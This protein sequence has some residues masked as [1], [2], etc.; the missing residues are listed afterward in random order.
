[1]NHSTTAWDGNQSRIKAYKVTF[2]REPNQSSEK[3]RCRN[4]YERH[5]NPTTI[6]LKDPS[7]AFVVPARN[8]EVAEDT[9]YTY[10]KLRMS[11]THLL[12]N[13]AA[14]LVSRK[15]QLKRTTEEPERWPLQTIDKIQCHINE[16]GLPN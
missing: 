8:A 5:I 2:R 3:C 4:P 15:S 16:E 13:N 12:N 11:P 6:Y 14:L 9:R 10:P 1:M 7:A